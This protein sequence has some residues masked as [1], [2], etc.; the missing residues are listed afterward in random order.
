[1]VNFAQLVPGTTAWCMLCAM[2][3]GVGVLLPWATLQNPFYHVGFRTVFG[4]EY[5][6]GGAIGSTFLV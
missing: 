4:F 1:M 5:W 6:Y 3:G 2:T